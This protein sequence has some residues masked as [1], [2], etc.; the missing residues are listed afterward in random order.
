MTSS[1]YHEPKLRYADNPGNRDLPT[2]GENNDPKP[3]CIKINQEFDIQG[4]H[5][6][7]T[8]VDHLSARRRPLLATLASAYTTTN[9]PIMPASSC[10]KIW[11]QWNM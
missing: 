1:R 6:A 11:Q 2:N 8:E 3:T 9:C 10:S 7:G 4:W 5:R